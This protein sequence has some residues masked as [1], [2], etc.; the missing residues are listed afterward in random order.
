M[1]NGSQHLRKHAVEE[2]AGLSS[3]MDSRDGH[4]QI[5]HYVYSELDP[6]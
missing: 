5:G 3:R 4:P 1:N 2:V 6:Q